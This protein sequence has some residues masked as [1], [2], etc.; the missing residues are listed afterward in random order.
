[1][2]ALQV[3]DFPQGLYDELKLSAARDHRSI[4]Q[5]VVALVDG[6]LHAPMPAAPRHVARVTAGDFA[7]DTEAERQERIRRR[8]EI[9][10]RLDA[11]PVTMP[12]DFPSPAEIVRA[13]R[14][15]KEEELDERMRHFASGGAR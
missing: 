13:I 2:P 1:M 10:A 14:D 6:A 12:S 11:N 15:D 7:F 8:K 3:R 4:A 5:Q 9:F